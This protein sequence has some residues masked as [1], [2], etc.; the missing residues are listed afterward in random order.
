MKGSGHDLGEPLPREVLSDLGHW[1]LYQSFRTFTWPW[2][3]R[4]G[5]LFWPIALVAGF[6]YAAWHSSGMGAW[7]DWPGLALRGCLAALLAVTAGP[8]LA[9]LI[10]HRRLP[11]AL[12]RVLI[13]GAILAGIAV[14]WAA[15]DWAGAYH[16]YLM[17][18][19]SGRPVNVSLFGRTVARLLLASIDAS[20]FVLVFAGGGLA[21]IYYLGERRRI[22]Q[23]TARHQ[24]A[25]VRAERDAAHM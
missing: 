17:E 22:A 19:Y 4:R 14:G 1:T 18:G 6:L 8:A 13:V 5:M 12:E 23:Y 21:V 9:T 25:R 24:L 3:L 15:L 7:A 20:L 10:R 11:I 2:L 16:A